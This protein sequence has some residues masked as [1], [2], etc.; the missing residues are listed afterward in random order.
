MSESDYTISRAGGAAPELARRRCAL[1]HPAAIAIIVFVSL[2]L[3][4]VYLGTGDPKDMMELFN[5]VPVK[6]AMRDG[7]W[8][9]PTLNG[10]PRL[11]KPPLPVWIPAGLGALFHTDSLWIL[12]LPSALVGVLAALCTYGIG[13]VLFEG[14]GEPRGGG[15]L[16]AL[17][18]ALFVPAMFV[19]NREARLASY[20]IYATGFLT[21]GAMFLIWMATLRETQNAKLKTQN[22]GGV[23]WCYAILAGI[24]TG[25][26]VLSKGPVPA[27][28]VMIP[29]GIWLFM[30]HN[31]A[32]VWGGV[33]LA[34][35]VS[36][37]TFLP[38]LLAIGG[39]KVG[40]H[41]IV[42]P[43]IERAWHVWAAEFLQFGTGDA[44]NPG[45]GSKAD[46]TDPIYYYL[47]MFIWVAPLTPSLVAG[48]V[49]PF[50][51][52]RDEVVRSKGNRRGLWLVWLV[53]VLGLV[54]LSVPS[55]KKGRYTLQLFPFA[56]LLCAAVWR[57]FARLGKEEI[58]DLGGRIVLAAQALCFIVP[59]VLGIGTVLWVAFGGGFGKW[60]DVVE[61][62][63]A[64][65]IPGGLVLFAAIAGAGIWLWREMLRRNFRTVGWGVALN[66]CLVTLVMM[67]AY[68][69]IPEMHTNATR[70]PVEAA[71]AE[72]HR[73]GAEMI[74]TTK[75]GRLWLPTFYFANQILPEM[76]ADDA[77]AWAKEH[78]GKELWL[79]TV[80]SQW[81]SKK[82]QFVPEKHAEAQVAA[83]EA[84]LGH[85]R[86]E[87]ANW[88]DE[89]RKTFLY[90]FGQ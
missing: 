73:D 28:T 81:D 59:G 5:L 30:Y 72:A 69:G 42:A 41:W 85:P 13:C 14:E 29:L 51:K 33:A 63:H 8:L 10:L 76:S 16:W 43:R 64:L 2:S 58:P 80:M 22:G 86:T 70:P 18:A 27:A 17:I 40:G 47:M 60:T 52:Q 46:L 78:P 61:A 7:H 37:M 44:A 68:R 57:E 67:W 88:V 38:W 35:A 49:M 74:A 36:V 48:L 79:V 12:R 31:R 83:I 53:L 21:C 50:L 77:A 11:E 55:E 25:L 54:M 66:A 89:G 75:A 20:D 84:A 19:F 45:A 62:V 24:A 90:R 23:F 56:G 34:A 4:L 39:L 87:A 71:F 65:S 32:R 82:T 1:S 26:S 3:V 15:R 6:E 9:M